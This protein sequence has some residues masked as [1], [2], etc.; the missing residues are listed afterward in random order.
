MAREY[1]IKEN[2]LIARLAALKLR[3]PKV[4]IVIGT[5]IHLHNTSRLEFLDDKKWLQHELC[6][7]EQFRKYGF[8]GFIVKYL[9]ETLKDGY[10]QNKFEREARAAENMI[11]D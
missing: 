6:H 3:S 11:P 9:W 2:S 8:I 7:V 5:T 10:Y 4:A 1:N